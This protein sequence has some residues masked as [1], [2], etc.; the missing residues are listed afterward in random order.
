M[1]IKRMPT[2]TRHMVL[3]MLA[4]IG[5]NS[6]GTDW[7]VTDTGDAGDGTCDATCTLREAVDSAGNGDR[8]LFDPAL[9][10]PVVVTLTGDALAID[11]LQAYA[12][13]ATPEGQVMQSRLGSI[14]AT[15]EKTIQQQ[16]EAM[17][18]QDESA[19]DHQSDS[20]ADLMREDQPTKP[21]ETNQHSTT[22]DAI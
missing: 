6:F 11:R 17:Q 5:G 19:A 7:V 16:A 15:L 21:V 1:L 13:I 12:D 9:P 22:E 8:I 2:P 14:V 18:R 3:L 4:S 20:P 10:P